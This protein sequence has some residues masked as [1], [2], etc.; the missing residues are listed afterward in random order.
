MAKMPKFWCVFS[1]EEIYKI[2]N[3]QEAEER[4]QN[5]AGENPGQNWYVLEL[6][7]GTVA[8]VT[9]DHEDIEVAELTVDEQRKALPENAP[10]EAPGIPLRRRGV[11][12]IQLF[13]NNPEPPI[14]RW[15][16]LAAEG[17][18]LQADQNRLQAER[19]DEEPGEVG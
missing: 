13:G 2:F 7:G 17:R 4:V 14:V 3:Q 11:R 10:R 8:K 9:I 6:V 19:E 15:D 5:M 16:E 1:E 18:Q 12:E